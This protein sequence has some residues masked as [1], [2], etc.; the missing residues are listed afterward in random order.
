MFQF[1]HSLI[2]ASLSQEMIVPLHNFLVFPI[3]QG[4]NDNFQY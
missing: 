3:S 2:L 1:K 4:Q